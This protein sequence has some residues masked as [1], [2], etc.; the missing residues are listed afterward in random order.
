MNCKLCKKPFDSEHNFKFGIHE[1]E[2][3]EDF[4]KHISSYTKRELFSTEHSAK[5]KVA[6][7]FTPNDVESFTRVTLIGYQDGNPVVI[8]KSGMMKVCRKEELL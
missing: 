5:M 1:S 8:L 2:W 4:F 3:T 7:P 6:T